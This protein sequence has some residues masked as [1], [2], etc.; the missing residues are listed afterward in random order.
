[1]SPRA[2]MAFR[3]HVPPAQ[4]P[5]LKNSAFD[6]M[7][8]SAFIPRAPVEPKQSTNR[9]DARRT[10]K[11]VRPLRPA[12]RPKT[13]TAPTLGPGHKL[14][15]DRGAAPGRHGTRKQV[16]PRRCRRPCRVRR[17]A[18]KCC[19][20]PQGS[21]VVERYRSP[22][23]ELHPISR[24]VAGTASCGSVGFPSYPSVITEKS[25]CLYPGSHAFSSSSAKSRAAHWPP[26]EGVA[27]KRSTGILQERLCPGR[28]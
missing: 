19:A 8:R 24:P 10:G 1:M 28:L 11:S 25:H 6:L 9:R 2:E 23:I 21:R 5:V 15:A 17:R 7:T 20:A 16:R 12:A 13:S 26:P 18:T 4:V 22:G 27:Q 3:R 14:S